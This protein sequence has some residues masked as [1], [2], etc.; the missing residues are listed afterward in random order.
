MANACG[1]WW[2]EAAH[3]A[4]LP[5]VQGLPRGACA[6]AVQRGGRQPL[7]AGRGDAHRQAGL[8]DRRDRGAQRVGQEQPGSCGL[9][10]AGHVGADLANAAAH[11]GGDRAT[12]IVRRRDRGAF[13]SGAG[14]RAVVAAALPCAEPGRAVPCQPRA[15]GVRG[16]GARGGGRVHLGG[17]PADC[18]HR[19]AGVRQG[20]APHQGPGD[21]AD[22]TSRRA[23]VAAAGL[24]VRYRRG[25]ATEVTSRTT[26]HRAGSA[27][28][29]LALLDLVRAA[30]LSEAAQDDRGHQL[31][32]HGRRAASGARGGVHAARHARGACLPSGGDAG[33]ARRGRGPALP[34]RLLRAVAH[35]AE[36]ARHRGAHAVPH[37]PPGA[38]RRAASTPRLDAGF[39]RAVRYEPGT[40]GAVYAGVSR[41]GAHAADG[42][43]R[44]GRPL[45][46][47]AG[48][49]YLGEGASKCD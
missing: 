27:R 28:H 23:A 47:C 12:R 4:R 32:G 29:R 18:A 34:E 11:R 21:P 22:A 16:A 48:F 24:G 7:R 46:G 43:R 37:Q 25:P 14:Q 42:Q 9:G 40:V 45:Q 8:A 19:R 15:S 5:G 41:K 2:Y 39:G 35:R 13:G 26:A 6:F 33:V 20:M 30:S 38:G 10:R 49:R 31:R 36:P 1:W 44:V 3:R 17:G